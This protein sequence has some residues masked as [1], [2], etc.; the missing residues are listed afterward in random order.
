M[1]Q[2]AIFIDLNSDH[3][4]HYPGLND[5][6]F[7]FGIFD[8]IGNAYEPDLSYYDI[9]ILETTVDRS[10]DTVSASVSPIS[11][12]RCIEEDFSINNGETLERIFNYSV[13]CP[14]HRNYTLSGNYGADVIRFVQFNVRRCSSNNSS[15]IT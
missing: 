13:Y 8:D 15:N 14:E 1:C 9:Q 6:Y 10:G 11:Y 7:A 4:L 3:K 2:Q 12:R 5:Y